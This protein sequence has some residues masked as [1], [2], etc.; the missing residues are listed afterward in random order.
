MEILIEIF[1][2]AFGVLLGLTWAHFGGPGAWRIPWCVASL[3][4]G[5]FATFASGEWRVSPLYFLFDIGLVA[6]VSAGTL[7]ALKYWQRQREKD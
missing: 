2:F 4:L 6:V 7:F 1:P 3:T 5:A